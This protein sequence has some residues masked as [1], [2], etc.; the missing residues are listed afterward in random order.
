MF[1]YL[2]T[3]KSSHMSTLSTTR[4]KDNYKIKNWKE[5][6]KSLCQRGSLSIW[7]E[8]SVMS[9]AVPN[10]AR[11]RGV[12]HRLLRVYVSTWETVV[13]WGRS[14]ERSDKIRI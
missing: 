6:I 5:Y 2:Q 8:D 7:L 12:F 11:N 9:K 10:T 3:Q 14:G 4:Y 13:E 1:L